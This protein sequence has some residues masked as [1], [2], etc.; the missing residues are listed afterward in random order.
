[1]TSQVAPKGFWLLAVAVL[2]C[3]RV[4]EYPD[5]EPER[6][7]VLCADA[8]DNDFDGQVDCDDPDCTGSCPEETQ[9]ACA[10]GR[11]NDGDGLT[12][13]ADPRC[14]P[15][16]PPVARRCAESKGVD[17]VENFDVLYW[18]HAIWQSW[19]RYGTWTA[20]ANLGSIAVGDQGDVVNA[21]AGRI[22]FVSSSASSGALDANL[23]VL[24]RQRPFAGAWQGFELAFQAWVPPGT[25]LRVGIVPTELAPSLDAPLPGAETKLFA[26]TLDRAK[27]APTVTLTVD[28]RDFSMPLAE[29]SCD[30]SGV[31]ASPAVENPC[32]AA[33]L[34]VRVTLDSDGFR[35]SLTGAGDSNWELRAPPPRSPSLAISRLV[36]WGGS[37]ALTRF[38]L[39]DTLRMRVA[40]DWP[41]GYAVPQIPRASCEPEAGTRAFGQGVSVARGHAG[42]YCALVTT[43]V[44]ATSAPQNLSAW[45]SA[46]G[47]EWSAASA[48]GTPLVETPEGA[49]LVGAGIAADA[50][51]WHV[52]VAYQRAQGVELGFAEGTS[53]GQLSALVRGPELFPD[54]EPPSYVIADG[55]HSV[56]FTRPSNGQVGRTLW[57]VARAPDAL[58]ELLAELPDDVG[59]PVSVVLAGS[60][61]LV[62][63]YPVAPSSD[64]A[65]AGL[66]VA[67]AEL[68]NWRR[69]EP[70]PVLHL[71]AALAT[72]E[73]QVAFDDRGLVA[74]AL[75][76]QAD[77]AFLLY[78]GLSAS[79]WTRFGFR[80]VLAVG[81]ASLS[82]ANHTT[83]SE[84]VVP[85][86]RCGDGVCDPGELCVTCES[87][88]PCSGRE[89]LS[90]VFES[91]TPWQIVSSAAHPE[92][93]AYL[94][95]DPPGL[96]WVGG[97]PTW[98]VLPLTQAIDGDFELSFD[99]RG[100]DAD[101]NGATRACSVYVGLGSVPEL[102]ASEERSGI[103]ARLALSP[104][105]SD[106]FSVAPF[107]KQEGASFSLEKEGFSFSCEGYQDVG[108]DAWQPVVLRRR[109]GVVSVVVPTS[110]ACG[111]SERTLTYAG[112]LPE[113]DALLI[114]FGGGSFDACQAHASAGTIA[115]L[116]LRLPDD[117]L[118][119]PASRTHCEKSST[120]PSCVDLAASSEHCGACGHACAAQESCQDGRC[121]C[122]EAL[123]ILE[124][125]GACV[126]T[127]SS[128]AHCGSCGHAC[129]ERCVRGRCDLM[130]DCVAPLEIPPSGGKWALDFVPGAE[131]QYLSV[132]NALPFWSPGFSILSWIPDVS[133]NAVI[134]ADVGDTSLNTLLVM[135]DQWDGLCFNWPQCNDDGAELG[136][137]SRLEAPVIAGTQYRI[138]VG[139]TRPTEEPQEAELRIRVEP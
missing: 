51:G 105:C 96:D 82:P 36:L 49:T 45:R 35:V 133:G 90:D 97:A 63:A 48:L 72:H 95:R 93:T 79:G 59:R 64:R 20:G 33:S 3:A 61:D 10:D 94:D 135:T 92:A 30:D 37:S 106:W 39:V 22:A 19:Q 87:D 102:D 7:A 50:G 126:D 88:C 120:E 29:A 66:L 86:G 15:F 121:T 84:A 42:D 136:L 65:G 115:N 28:G 104:Y 131:F 81:T 83:P 109:G 69:I 91:G 55:R 80:D 44:D 1:V 124:C 85:S 125:D 75:S 129:A 78:S 13:A 100:A 127:S 123:G 130:G 58:P 62:L 89:L 47:K 68:R 138:G 34:G 56:Y 112:A 103:F 9:S 18:G 41:C 99:V 46:D 43:S 67:D 2:G 57:R 108:P 114:G 32:Q 74:T 117:P 17:I 73:G 77:A 21:I 8:T 119:C 16:A 134:E 113:L 40:A 24:V 60:K 5:S 27:S 52:A 116:K 6:G 101:N 12:D 71:P 4:L 23:G 137:G 14:W 132:C 107:V 118:D 111:A 70:S 25:M 38:A 26:L 128:I 98:S 139:L 54:A 31:L 122:S 76:W 53:C 110:F 11:D